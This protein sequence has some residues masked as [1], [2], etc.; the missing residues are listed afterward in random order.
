M[1]LFELFSSCYPFPHAQDGSFQVCV[2]LDQLRLNR[3]P[4]AGPGPSDHELHVRNLPLHDMSRQQLSE[5]FQGFGEV[6]ELHVLL[7]VF[8][9]QTNEGRRP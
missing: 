9:E 8:G 5:Y 2:F 3:R 6:E 1:I 4:S 7:D